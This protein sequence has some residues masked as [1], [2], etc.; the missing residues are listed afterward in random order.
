MG[1]IDASGGKIE[2]TSVPRGALHFQAG[3]QEELRGR[4]GG[5]E[6][7]RDRG[8]EGEGKGELD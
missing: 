6:R 8:R 3:V 1:G 5:R 4:D 2:K 7:G